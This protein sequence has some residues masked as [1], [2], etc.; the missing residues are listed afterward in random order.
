MLSTAVAKEIHK[1]LNG[2]HVIRVRQYRLND[3]VTMGS[4]KGLAKTG[5]VNDKLEFTDHYAIIPTGSGESALK[6]VSFC[7]GQI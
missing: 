7:P 1:N 6:S 2:L 5:Y 3:I 4:H